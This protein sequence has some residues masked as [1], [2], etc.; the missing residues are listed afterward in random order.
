MRRLGEIF[1]QI[2][3]RFLPDP[4]VLACLLTLFVIV[5]AVCAPQAQS[6][7]ALGLGERSLEVAGMWAGAVWNPSFLA[8]ALQMCVVLLTGFGLAKAPIALRGLRLIA[9]LPACNR[10][11]VFLIGLVSCA[12]C[13]VNWGFGLILAG[14][15]AAEV[16]EVLA[17]KGVACQFPLIVA[18]AYAGMMVW[19]GGFSGS[20]PLKVASEG[21]TVAALHDGREI[22]Q[23]LAPPAIDR[24]ILSPANLVLT[25]VLLIGVPLT[26]RWMGRVRVV[27]DAEADSDIEPAAEE[28]RPGRG[29]SSSHERSGSGRTFADVLNRTWVVPVAVAAIIF[30]ALGKQLYGSGVNAIGLDFVNSALLALGLLLHGNL[31]SYVRAVT[32]G[33]RAVVGIVIQFPLYSGIQGLMLGSGLALAISEW[34]VDAS[35]WSAN[36]LSISVSHT[37]PIATFFSAAVVN[38]FIPSGGGQWIVQGPIMCGAAHTLSMPIDQTVMAIAYGDELTNMIQP[39]WAIPLMGLTR[40]NAREFM[41]YC[42]LLMLLAVPAFCVALLCY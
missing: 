15:L 36:L 34:F 22:A 21:V 28:A 33:G 19:H 17:R 30:V 32:D 42:A 31:L 13:W 7:A 11:A 5:V 3:R 9:G 29:E 1:A 39:F 37:F 2:A 40:V 4:M 23:T 24:T 12:G 38:L 25:A 10:D 20:A 14:V 8:F 6:L 26:L 18:A 27:A 35:Q 41:G 16:R